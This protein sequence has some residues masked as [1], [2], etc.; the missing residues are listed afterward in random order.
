MLIILAENVPGF[1]TRLSLS[2][3][4]VIGKLSE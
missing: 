1:A 2:H 4:K 3:I